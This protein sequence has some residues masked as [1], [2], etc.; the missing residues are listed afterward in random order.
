MQTL[1]ISVAI[2][3]S[4]YRELYYHIGPLL[5]RSGDVSSG[6]ALEGQPAWLAIPSEAAA[7]EGPMKKVA[8]MEEG[9]GGKGLRETVKTTGRLALADSRELQDL[10]AVVFKK[11]E[12]AKGGLAEVQEATGKAYD[13]QSTVLREKTKTAS[14]STTRA[15]ARR[16]WPSS[17]RR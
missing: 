15:G 3:F 1:A 10:A 8:K 2:W 7:S 16:T 17:R 6:M 11:F 12:V 14:R 9:T 5:S 4:T 13:A